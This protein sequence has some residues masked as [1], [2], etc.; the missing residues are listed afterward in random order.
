MNAN[1]GV[2]VCMA[3]SPIQSAKEGVKSVSGLL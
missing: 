3:F 1:I 2:S